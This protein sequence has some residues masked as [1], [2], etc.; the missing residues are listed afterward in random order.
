[1]KKYISISKYVLLAAALFVF[2]SCQDTWKDHYSFK[3]TESKY[4]V[5]K[6]AETLDGINGFGNFYEALRTTKMCDKR[7]VPQNMTF[8]DLLMEDQFITVWAPSDAS[9]TDWSDYINKNKTDAEHYEVGEKFIK[10]HIAR[11]KHSVGSDS[12]IVNMLNG[13]KYTIMPEGISGQAYHGDDINIR[14]S[15]GVLHCIDGKLDFLPNIYSYL[16]TAPD[17]KTR[18][19]DWFK[20]FTV[21]ELDLTESV[22]GGL[23][24]NGEIWYVDSVTYDYSSLMSYYGR[25]V[26]EDSNYVLVLPT[27]EVWDQVYDRISKSFVYAEKSADNDSLQ[28]Y[29][30]RTTMLTDLFFNMNKKIQRYLP[31]SVVSTLYSAAENRQEG[32]PYHVFGH[33][34]AP[35]GLFGGAIETIECSNG[36]VYIIDNW[37]F[38]DSLTYLRTLRQEA[39]DIPNLIGFQVKSQPLSIVG[40]DTLD[41]PI[42][43]MRISQEGVKDWTL[44]ID[45]YDNLKGKYRLSIVLAPNTYDDMPNYVHPVVKYNLP[46]SKDPAVLADST[47]TYVIEIPGWDPIVQDVPYCLVNDMTKLDTLEVGVIDIPYCNYDMP[48][49][50]LYLTLSSEV[51]ELNS[52]LYSSEIWLDAIILEPIVE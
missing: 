17:Y 11:F 43:V 22:P 10:N 36:K 30:T 38:A 14:C 27:P 49:S 5:A 24:E 9:I 25:I 31:D 1:M 7:G 16:T 34:Y 21:A 19:G 42:Q 8:L 44:N 18:L 50:K 13:K 52:E 41:K 12:I 35:N 20:S 46:D 37:P 26:S 4:P 2:G 32:K 29:Y 51:N 48:K 40:K 15:N 39:E 28:Q 33:P 45:I 3:E 47:T 6:I 23:N